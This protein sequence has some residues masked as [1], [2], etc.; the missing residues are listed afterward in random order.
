MNTFI[1]DGLFASFNMPL[2]PGRIIDTSGTPM[3]AQWI[4]VDPADFRNHGS[5]AGQRFSIR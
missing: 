2:P 5:T 3:H 4:W 1:G